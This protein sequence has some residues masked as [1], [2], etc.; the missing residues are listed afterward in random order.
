MVKIVHFILSPVYVNNKICAPTT[1]S[2]AA[3]L[4][5]FCEETILLLVVNLLSLF[6]TQQTF[7]RAKH[8]LSHKFKDRNLT[9]FV[10]IIWVSRTSGA[11]NII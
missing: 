3:R 7:L 11:L 10:S 6:I 9:S 8:E 1:G 5:R 2:R 4:F